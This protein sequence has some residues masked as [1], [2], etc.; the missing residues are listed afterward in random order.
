VLHHVHKDGRRETALQEKVEHFYTQCNALTYKQGLLM[1]WNRFKKESQH[2][3]LCGK[4]SRPSEF[5]WWSLGAIVTGVDKEWK[6]A[7]Y[8][9]STHSG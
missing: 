5:P 9:V 1:I 2:G 7:L 8:T 4:S 6:P 3:G